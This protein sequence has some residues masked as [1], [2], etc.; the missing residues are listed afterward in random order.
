MLLSKRGCGQRGKTRLIGALLFALSLPTVAQDGFGW[1]EA[2]LDRVAEVDKR[3]AGVLG[4]YVKD[5]DSGVSA[6]Y[7]GEETWYLAST[8]KVPVAIA[9]MRR[10]EEG[11]LSLDSTVQLLSS[12]YVDGAG[13][14]NAEAP[15]SWLSIRFL[16][17]Q[18]LIHSDNTA[19]DMLIRVAGI[20]SVNAVA[21]ELVPGG[22]GPIT[23]LADVRRLVYSQLHPAAKNLSGADFLLLRQQSSE[24]RRLATLAELLKVERSS[25][26]PIGVGEAFERYYA[27]PFNSAPLTAYGELLAALVEGRALQPEATAYLLGVMRRVETGSLR[28]KAGL[29]TTV[30]FAH[31][32]GTQVARACD[33][34]VVVPKPGASAEG[35]PRL[36]VVACV[37]GA[38]TARAETALRGAGE[39][40]VASGLMR[41]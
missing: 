32:T 13:P 23:T 28:I 5:V 29:P 41:L 1:T 37:R 34:G 7:R 35:A 9:I 25:F 40:L 16:L 2:F 8:I 22:F 14:T 12:D 10:V 26:T 20:D 17:D 24:E 39:A 18:M 30:S 11:S 33:A 6:S 4:V 27:T 15:G 19:S 36:V 21:Q 38:S 31:K 3:T